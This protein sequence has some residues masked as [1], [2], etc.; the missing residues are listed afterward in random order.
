[1]PIMGTGFVSELYPFM[2]LVLGVHTSAIWDVC[3]GQKVSRF[4]YFVNCYEREKGVVVLHLPTGP[5]KTNSGL[6]MQTQYLP[7]HW[8]MT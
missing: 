5:L 1:M 8:P 3:L 7:A 6:E 4:G 2:V